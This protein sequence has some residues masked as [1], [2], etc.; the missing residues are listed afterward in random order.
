MTDERKKRQ[1][2][3][4]DPEPKKSSAKGAPAAAADAAVEPGPG[5]VLHTPSIQEQWNEQYKDWN[6]EHAKLIADVKLAQEKLWEHRN[7][8]I[9]DPQ[10]VSDA[11]AA[12]ERAAEKKS[13]KSGTKGPL[14]K[15]ETR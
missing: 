8:I 11:K 1:E 13:L 6:E 4:P 10:L 9:E 2:L 12:E 3:W 7:P 15:G 14:A 5:Q